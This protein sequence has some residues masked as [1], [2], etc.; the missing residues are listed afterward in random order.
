[1]SSDRIRCS[2]AQGFRSGNLRLKEHGRIMEIYA[3]YEVSGED[4][5]GAGR[6]KAGDD[7]LEGLG[8]FGWMTWEER[9]LYGGKREG[10]FWAW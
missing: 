2:A 7:G 6:E 9:I 4:E 10:N 3:I 8:E 5:G 1:M